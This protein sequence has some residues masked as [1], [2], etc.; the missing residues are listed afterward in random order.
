MTL[1]CKTEPSDRT[2]NHMKSSK[3]DSKFSIRIPTPGLNM[4]LFID[5]TSTMAQ[6]YPQHV[7]EQSVSPV[8]QKIQVYIKGMYNGSWL[9]LFLYTQ[10]VRICR[11]SLHKGT[12]IDW[13]QCLPISLQSMTLCLCQLWF[14][15]AFH[16][17]G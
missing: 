6:T 13:L 1:S 2:I 9:L 10:I 16:S 12:S 7:G 3:E 14:L 17:M 11:C 4:F 8:T 15:F 5:P